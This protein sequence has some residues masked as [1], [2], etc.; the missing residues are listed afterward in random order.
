MEV[1]SSYSDLLW[2]ITK[3]MT[4]IFILII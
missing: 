3:F 4:G 2:T 1:V